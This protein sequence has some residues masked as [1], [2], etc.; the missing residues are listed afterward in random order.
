MDFEW[1]IAATLTR[2]ISMPIAYLFTF[3]ALY[4]Y[5]INKKL[6]NHND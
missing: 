2:V 1:G 3:F 6:I 5:Q 4:Q